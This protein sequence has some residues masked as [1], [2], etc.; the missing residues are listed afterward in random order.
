MVLTLSS[1]EISAAS[2]TD[3]YEDIEGTVV[4]LVKQVEVY[5]V[6]H[7]GS[8]YSSNKTWMQKI[9]PAIGVIS[10][11]NGNRYGHPTQE[12]L[13]RLHAASVKTYWTETGE[14]A[15]PD[16]G[17]DTVGGNIIVESSPG[18]NTFTV[19]HSGVQVDTYNNWEALNDPAAQPA[20]APR[21]AWSKKSDVYH[22]ISCKW[23]DN[24]SPQN[25][26]KGSAA[27]SGKRLHTGC[28]K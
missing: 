26:Q 17:W 19:T 27:P 23:V 16:P 20:A 11:G 4:G 6:H 28:P 2:K 9:K 5:K 8:R 10:T 15:D 22:H 24:I 25:L 3:N 14:G 13:D 12:C 7:H 1:A 21:F 18:S